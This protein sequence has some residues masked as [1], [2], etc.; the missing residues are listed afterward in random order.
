MSWWGGG[1]INITPGVEWRRRAISTETLK[2]GSCPPSPGLAP[3]ATL[4][5]IS[6]HWFRYSAVTPNRP[7]ATCLIAEFQLSPLASG[8]NRAGSS[9]PSPLS[10]FAPIRFMATLSVPCASALSAP[11]DMPGVMN[12]RRIP[13]IDSTSSTETGWRPDLKSRRSRSV[14][15]SVL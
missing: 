7:E 10:D 3:W 8:L 12:R 14:T 15:G 6:R 1:L 5:S 2:P 9:P 4:I 11:S 13:V